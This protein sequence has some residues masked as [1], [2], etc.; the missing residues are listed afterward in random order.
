[1]GI[2]AEMFIKTKKR[3]SEKEVRL[4]AV[5]LYSLYGKDAFCI[6]REGGQHC[7]AIQDVIEQDGPDIVPKS[8]EQFIRVFLYGRYY[9]KEYERGPFYL[10]KSIAETLEIQF[11]GCEVW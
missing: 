5:Q 3:Y 10:Y 9:G 4:A 8:G 7:L 6:N 2:D 1:M 11:P